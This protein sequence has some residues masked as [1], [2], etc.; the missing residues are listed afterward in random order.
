MDQGIIKTEKCVIVPIGT[1]YSPEPDILYYGGMYYRNRKYQVYITREA[2]YESFGRWVS[3]FPYIGD[4]LIGKKEPPK[5]DD[6]SPD[7]GVVKFRDG[8]YCPSHTD[9]PTPR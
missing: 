8:I 4:V 3:N 7:F 5:I 2:F 9:H 1:D 6:F